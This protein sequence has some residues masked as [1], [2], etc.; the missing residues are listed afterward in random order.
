MGAVTDLEVDTTDL[1]PEQLAG[2]DP[3][4][5]ITGPKGNPGTRWPV[6]AFNF[7]ASTPIQVVRR[8]CGAI[9]PLGCNAGFAYNA[10]YSSYGQ[11][12]CQLQA[13]R[14][15]QGRCVLQGLFQGSNGVDYPVNPFMMP[16][17]MLPVGGR[18]CTVWNNANGRMRG[19]I[20][21]NSYA[22]QYA[23]QRMTGTGITYSSAW[24]EVNAIYQCYMP[25]CWVDYGLQVSN[26][27]YTYTVS[28][29]QVSGWVKGVP[30]TI[31]IP[32]PVT[33][34]LQAPTQPS[35]SFL[36]FYYDMTLQRFDHTWVTMDAGNYW[37]P[38]WWMSMAQQG[39]VVLCI[40]AGGTTIYDHRFLVRGP[41]L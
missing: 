41:L 37:E 1:R 15:H 25:Q 39:Q 38:R 18:T 11:G 36:A 26:V 29:G 3:W 7:A 31:A 33:V 22:G 9:G 4:V 35:S 8:F 24:T 30:V 14:D 23:C 27:G 32:N 34:T 16:W 6:P 17:D 12:Y 19:D 21:S 5:L 40:P 10:G 2:P 20:V 28:S 13:Y